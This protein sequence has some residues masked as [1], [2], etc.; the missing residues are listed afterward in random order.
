MEAT[1][2]NGG[3]AQ[4]A[5]EGAHSAAESARSAAESAQS[6]PA[7]L[8]HAARTWPTQQAVVDTQWGAT[9]ELTYAE[10]LE[11]VRDF[12]AA[13]VASGFSPGDRGAIW[14]PNSYHWPIAALGIQ[15]AG[16]VLVPLN[17]RYTT[18]EAVDV[19]E[20]S[21]VAAVVVS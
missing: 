16:G 2:T 15:Y 4:S 7:A 1:V 21:Q 13:L 18:T 9:V 12:A 11:R 19:I 3:D 14:S 8:A 6:T 17:T 5:A 10:L 20:R